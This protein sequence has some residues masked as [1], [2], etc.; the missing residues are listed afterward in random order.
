MSPHPLLLGYQLYLF[1]SFQ[2]LNSF[3][4]LDLWPETL[5]ALG[6]IKSRFIIGIFKNLR[7]LSITTVL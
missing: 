5:E 1:Q 2:K 7:I 4:A 3:W 6:I